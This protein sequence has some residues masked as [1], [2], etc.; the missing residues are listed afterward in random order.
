MMLQQR[1][2]VSTAIPPSAYTTSTQGLGIFP[3]AVMSAVL[4]TVGVFAILTALV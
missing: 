4:S 1:S 3:A 2:T